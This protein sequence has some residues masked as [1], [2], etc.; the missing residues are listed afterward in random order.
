VGKKPDENSI[1]S[2]P[3]AEPPARA[4]YDWASIAEQLRGDP[5]EWHKVFEKGRVAVSNAVRQG[6]IAAVHPDLG[7]ETTTTHNTR[8]PPRTCTLYLRFNPSKVRN[9]LRETIRSTRKG[10]A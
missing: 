9:E 1:T 8:T 10:K 5:M 3:R 4:T 6:S 2:L 7:F